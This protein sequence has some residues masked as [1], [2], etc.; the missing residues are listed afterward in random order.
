MPEILFSAAFR[1]TLRPDRQLSAAFQPWLCSA[2]PCSSADA[3]ITQPERS[4][5][6][7][8]T[9]DPRSGFN[10][11]T[12]TTSPS[13]DP[14]P[15]QGQEAPRREG[16]TESCVCPVPSHPSGWRTG[17][18]SGA[19]RPAWPSRRPPGP[20]GRCP[21]ARARPSRCR[22]PPCPRPGSAPGSGGQCRCGG[23]GWPRCGAR[24]MPASPFPPCRT[25]KERGR[26][27]GTGTARG[28]PL[29]HSFL[30]DVSD[31]C[32]MEGGLLSL[33]SDFH[34]GK[35]QA[36]GERQGGWGGPEGTGGPGLAGCDGSRPWAQG[37]SAPSSSWST[38][39]RCRR[40]WH[41]CTS[42]SMSA[43]RSSPRS[44]RRRRLTGTW[45]SCWHT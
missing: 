31:V 18:R 41:G 15:P 25:S 7:P 35:L 38:C 19:P 40:S 8:G 11:P 1:K 44:R 26:A 33:L 27:G 37:R 45:T 32:E 21:P 6:C 20:C 28:A 14:N 42:A 34:S 10:P 23:D 17:G 29:Q 22:C 36:F 24:A 12:A 43:W 5:W 30:T 4:C 9:G 2:P 13:G 16:A 39:G 3:G